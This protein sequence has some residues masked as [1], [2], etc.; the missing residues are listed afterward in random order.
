MGLVEVVLTV[1]FLG[2]M[3]WLILTYIPMPDLAKKLIIVAIVAFVVL[4][5]LQSMGISTGIKVHL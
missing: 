3:F 4:F 1:T 5:I 2:F